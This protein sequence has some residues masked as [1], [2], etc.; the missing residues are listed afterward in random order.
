MGIDVIKPNEKSAAAGVATGD[1][2]KVGFSLHSVP[3]P[4]MNIWLMAM[5]ASDK[6]IF[7]WWNYARSLDEDVTKL[8]AMTGISSPQGLFDFLFLLQLR[9]SFSDGLYT[10][11]PGNVKNEGW[12]ELNEPARAVVQRGQNCVYRLEAALHKKLAVNWVPF[13]QPQVLVKEPT[14]DNIIRF[15]HASKSEDVTNSLSFVGVNDVRRMPEVVKLLIQADEKRSEKLVQAVDWFAVYSS[16]LDD[17]HGT[18]AMVYTQ[19]TAVVGVLAQLQKQ[20]SETLEAVRKALF[21]EP[22][23]ATVLKLLSRFIAL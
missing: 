22:T 18:C 13:Y 14:A 12:K 16:P 23:P 17:K 10:L 1:L 3:N 7:P 20:F 21:A 11:V 8:S 6:A 4:A 19:S 2:A 9:R 15:F 5:P